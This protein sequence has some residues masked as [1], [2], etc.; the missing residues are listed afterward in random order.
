M[1]VGTS[2]TL[3]VQGAKVQDPTLMALGGG[4]N[5]DVKMS[6]GTQFG[7]DVQTMKLNTNIFNF[8]RYQQQSETEAQIYL[9]SSDVE[10]RTSQLSEI[11]HSEP[12]SMGTLKGL[13]QLSIRFE[14]R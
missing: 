2:G 5:K 1:G 3:W 7:Y 8:V 6:I 11:T 14:L 9:I 13:T 4:G 10:G 12:I